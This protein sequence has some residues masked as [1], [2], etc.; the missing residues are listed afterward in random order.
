MSTPAP[1]SSVVLVELDAAPVLLV[2]AED[3]AVDALVARRA[4]SRRGP[5]RR[6]GCRSRRSAATASCS[7]STMRGRTNHRAGPADLVPGVRRERLVLGDDLFEAG[8]W[9]GRVRRFM[10]GVRRIHSRSTRR[11]SDRGRSPRRCPR[12]SS[13]S[14]RPRAT[15]A[16]QV[17]DDRVETSAGASRLLAVVR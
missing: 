9:I 7:S 3:R 15:C 10:H 6:S 13:R 12:P 2:E 17:L 4:G 16:A 1:T 5:A 8:E 14:G 11:R